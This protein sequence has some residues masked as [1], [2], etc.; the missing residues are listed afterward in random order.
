MSAWVQARF[1]NIVNTL[2]ATRHGIYE[3]LDEPSRMIRLLRLL[4]G[5]GDQICCELMVVSLDSHPSYESLS[6]VWGNPKKTL[7]ITL[8][9][10]TV[11]VTTNLHDALRRLRSKMEPRLV[12][13]DALCINQS[14]IKEKTIQV[15]LMGHIYKSCRQVLIWL[16]DTD[17][18]NAHIVESTFNMTQ[19]LGTKEHATPPGT[20]SVAPHL[21]QD[22]DRASP[23]WKLL[24]NS[25]WFDR[26]W[27]AQEFILAPSAIVIFGENAVSW[28]T[29]ANVPR[30][31]SRIS[32]A[33]CVTFYINNFGRSPGNFWA[34]HALQDLRDEHRSRTTT[35]LGALEAFVNRDASDPR[36][37]VFA[38]LGLVTDWGGQSPMIPDYSLKVLDVYVETAYKAILAEKSLSV[39]TMSK[40]SENPL[41]LPSWVPDWHINLPSRSLIYLW[42]TETSGWPSDVSKYRKSALALCGKFVNDVIEVGKTIPQDSETR[43]VGREGSNLTLWGTHADEI[44]EVGQILPE[45]SKLKYTPRTI[46]VVGGWLGIAGLAEAPKLTLALD[47]ILRLITNGDFNTDTLTE[48]SRKAIEKWKT[49]RYDQ[50]SLD[51]PS[52]GP[53]YSRTHQLEDL[54]YIES[55][56]NKPN[57]QKDS[58]HQLTEPINIIQKWCDFCRMILATG[59]PDLLTNVDEFTPV[60]I[61]A[62][63][64]YLAWNIVHPDG[65]GDL[66]HTSEPDSLGT[67]YILQFVPAYN[68][69]FITQN[70]LMGISSGGMCP[71]DRIF[72]LNSAQCPFILRSLKTQETEST[73]QRSAGGCYKLVS[74][75]YLDGITRDGAL[76]QYSEAWRQI[77]LH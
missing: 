13:V 8:N 6:Y 54:E 37:K 46:A 28:Q 56:R 57:A 74:H 71:G 72:I 48:H 12:W 15:G 63:A 17:L 51:V 19:V 38:L 2:A 45:V 7:P 33:E 39:L 61:C 67:G 64:H 36:D 60:M 40:K 25:A 66:G 30:Y 32:C 1:H 14:N 41:K 34:I 44:L 58:Q 69:F 9:N 55:V 35:L 24:I 47:R 3:E 65:D 10:H 5:H 77:C 62:A 49:L 20:I 31:T 21:S 68:G 18:S 29:L 26:I 23:G 50:G 42:C 75:C 76:K 70:G 53:E 59:D 11:K 27:T 73:L 16:G 22:W 4:P 52:L 43:A